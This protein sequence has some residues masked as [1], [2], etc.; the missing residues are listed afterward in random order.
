MRNFAEFDDY[1]HADEREYDH[2]ATRPNLGPAFVAG[3]AARSSERGTGNDASF[4]E[5]P[6]GWTTS[7]A[8]Y[9]AARVH[10]AAVLA[11][12]VHDAI[13]AVRGW[14]ERTRLRQQRR[15]QMHGI[16]RAL[17]ELDDVTLR[18]LGFH[19][20]EILSVAA[21][22]VGE[23]ERTRVRASL[24]PR[25]SRATTGRGTKLPERRS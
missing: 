19:R 15:Q 16:Y 9:H 11:A 24:A 21:E 14:V 3:T 5:A 22:A 4:D 20:C 25:T 1:L 18:D 17:H 23:A 12:L 7:Y 8:L 10:R 2:T 13:R 6:L